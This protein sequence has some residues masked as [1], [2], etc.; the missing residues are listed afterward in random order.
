MSHDL[1]NCK[2]HP[3]ISRSGWIVWIENYFFFQQLYYLYKYW[4]E[5][6]NLLYKLTVR[7]SQVIINS[8]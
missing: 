4:K 5:G 6:I 8:S 3:V 7:I 2:I 1:A